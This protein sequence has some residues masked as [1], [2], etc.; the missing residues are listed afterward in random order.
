MSKMTI[1]TFYEVVKENNNLAK[2]T[3]CSTKLSRG[4]LDKRTW[5]TSN[6]NRHLKNKHEI[7]WKSLIEKK[8]QNE[9][10]KLDESDVNPG[11]SKITTATSKKAK[12]ELVRDTIPD[13]VEIKTKWGFHS[14]EA[15][16]RHKAIFEEIVMD[17]RPFSSVNN[18]GFVRSHAIYHPQFEIASAKYYR[19][20]V[21]K[22]YEKVRSKIN[23]HIIKDNPQTIAIQLDG[24]SAYHHGYLGVNITYIHEWERKNFNIACTPFDESHTGSNLFKLLLFITDKWEITSKIHAGVR[25]NAANVKKL[26]KEDGCSWVD[27]GCLNHSLQ[28][29]IKAN[30]FCLTSVEAVIKKAKALASFCNSSNH[31]YQQIMKQQE[32]HRPG[33]PS[34]GLL[35]DVETRWNSTFDMLDRIVVL[36]KC[37]SA[38]I[39]DSNNQKVAELELSKHDF[40]L[41][42]RVVLILKK[43]YFPNLLET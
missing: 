9:K 40:L 37:I 35:N 17:M 19:D 43:E 39:A 1:W 13:W 29:V 32:T 3:L 36:Q 26:F 14:I 16:K 30:L 23:N 4:G 24:W 6:M 8:T 22:V 33:L 7:E 25:D 12:Q 2:C 5:G 18:A 31:F 11:T 41:I 10:R 42:E 38:A 34:L 20:Q 15:E 21:D 28:L 27:F